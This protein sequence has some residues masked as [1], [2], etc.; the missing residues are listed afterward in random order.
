MSQ[1]RPL[2]SSVSTPWISVW[3]SS[4]SR[5]Y[6]GRSASLSQGF[7]SSPPA[8]ANKGVRWYHQ[9][10]RWL[11]KTW[12]SSTLHSLS[13]S[14]IWWV[15]VM[16]FIQPDSRLRTNWP[17]GGTF[18][19][20]ISWFALQDQSAGMSNK[21][22]RGQV[23]AAWSVTVHLCIMTSMLVPP[24]STRGYMGTMLTSLTNTRLVFT[25]SWNIRYGVSNL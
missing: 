4:W 25:F 15:S 19:T 7:G 23:N 12:S 22:N 17:L 16:N 24:K 20:R 8:P 3:Q 5:C 9:T 11:A 18:E 1:R 13:S 6:C 21:I 14:A 2:T 10:R